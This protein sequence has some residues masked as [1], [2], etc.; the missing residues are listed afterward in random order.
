MNQEHETIIKT[1][2]SE[3]FDVSKHNIH[4]LKR[5][6]GGMSNSNYV[7]RIDGN[8]FVFRIPGNNAEYFVSREVEEDTLALADKVGIDGGLTIA[9]DKETGYK[10]SEYVEGTPL[11]K[12]DPSDYYEQA[13]RVLHTLHD[14]KLHAPN[15]YEPFKR[16]DTYQGYV[17]EKGLSHDESYVEIKNKLLDEREWLMSFE[18]VFC[19][20]DAQ[21]SNFIATEDGR[22]LL[23]DWE[24]GGDNDPLYDLACYGN[25]DFAYAE[26]I[27]P[28]YLGRTPEDDEWR[29]LYLWRTFQCLQWY[30]VAMFKEATGLSEELGLDFKAIAEQY[31]E[32]AN[33]MYAK[34][35]DYQGNTRT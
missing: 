30:N 15:D 19:H 33:A 13:S 26:G 20:G 2:M 16:L 24:F 10:I 7:V 22:L 3:K 32:K 23:V 18:R 29:R 28:V 5:L 35:G 21:P 4:V 34:A 9:M 25:N 12:L 17:E 11:F 8:F 31:I 6:E 1:L 27:L 14:A